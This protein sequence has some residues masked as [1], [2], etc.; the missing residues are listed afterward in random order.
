MQALGVNWFLVLVQIINITLLVAWLVLALIALTRLAHS[1]LIGGVRL[2][3]AALIV[4]V[5]MIGALAF[6][7]SGQRR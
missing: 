3:W 7:I 2:G 1:D 4:L 5:P 6:L